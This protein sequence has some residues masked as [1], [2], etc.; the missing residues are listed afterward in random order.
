SCCVPPGAWEMRAHFEAGRLMREIFYNREGQRLLSNGRV[1]PERV[2]GVPDAA[3]YEEHSGR[4]ALGVRHPDSGQPQ[5]EWQ[6]WTEAGALQEQSDCTEG[7]KIRQR[8]F[9]AAGLRADLRFDGEG[10]LDGVCFRRFTA[11]AAGLYADERIAAE[12]GAYQAGHAVGT[13]T[14][15]DAD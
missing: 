2:P 7:K 15:L 10:R 12:R 9:D 4:W 8:L 13:W 5:G 1:R 11:D 3:D 6:S 14:W